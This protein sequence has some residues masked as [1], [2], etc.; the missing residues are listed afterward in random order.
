VIA[1]AVLVL[2]VCVPA[3]VPAL[4]GRGGGR[5]GRGGDKPQPAAQPEGDLSHFYF[6]TAD[7]DAD[8]W[9]YMSEAEKSLGLDKAG[10][11]AF[12]KD[13]DG[14]ISPDEFAARYQAVLEKGGVFAPPT[15]KPDSNRPSRKGPKELMKL[16]DVDADGML[17]ES[18][19]SQALSAAKLSEPTAETILATLDKDK[20]G[21]LEG[22]EVEELV[23]IL[24]PDAPTTKP[25]KPKTLEQ[26][27]G[28]PEER[29]TRASAT[30]GPP[31]ITGPV[32]VY[33]RLD[34]DQSGMVGLSDLE[35]LQRPLQSSVRAPAVLA[36]MDANGDGSITALE[37]AE[38]MRTGDPLRSR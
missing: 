8:G 17:V 4:Q 34:F 19:V 37:F 3:V 27:F 7:W 23:R 2:L 20:S 5:G 36:T 29:S 31:R 38:S 13:G 14:S 32:P 18:E 9:I 1:R 10:F 21:G 15:P 24:S 6:E 22:A 30:I 33:V 25:R 11:R 35:E 12:D 16:H 28:R 26:L